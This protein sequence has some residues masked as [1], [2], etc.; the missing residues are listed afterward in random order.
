MKINKEKQLVEKTINLDDLRGCS[1]QEWIN[2]LTDL[3]DT[4]T[5]D[6]YISVYAYYEAVTIEF[7]YKILETDKEYDARIQRETDDYKRE[8][9]R[10]QT[11]AEQL[12]K[13]KESKRLEL[14]KKLEELSKELEDLK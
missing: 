5:S 14:E 6:G 7:D 10:K 11:E 2:K 13:A 8:Q 12:K 4:L 3:R 1:I 9:K